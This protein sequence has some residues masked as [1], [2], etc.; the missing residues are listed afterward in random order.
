MHHATRTIADT[1]ID[2]VFIIG[3]SKDCS[4]LLNKASKAV[5]SRQMH[6][7][8]LILNALQIP[9]LFSTDCAYGRIT[10]RGFEQTG[11]TG[12]KLGFPLCMD[13]ERFGF[14]AIS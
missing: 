5:E 9:P 10:W 11:L 6:T 1:L 14:Q 4:L 12:E 7:P 13:D 2:L 8:I 3:T